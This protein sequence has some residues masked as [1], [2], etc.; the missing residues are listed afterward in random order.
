MHAARH[1]AAHAAVSGRHFAVAADRHATAGAAAAERYDVDARLR[2]LVAA[3]AEAER[4]ARLFRTPREEREM[5]LMRRPVN[6]ERA[7]ELFGLLLGTL[8]PAAIFF[9]LALPMSRS[10]GDGVALLFIPMLFICAALG[11]VM[12]RRVGR[13]IG[14]YG[15]AGWVRHILFTIAASFGWAAVTGAAGGVLFF[16]VGAIFGVF[17]AIAVALPAFVVFTVLHRLLARGGMIDARH[18]RPLAWAVAATAAALLLSP[19]LLPY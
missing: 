17:C 7:Y 11:R 5:L 2:W 19:A 1:T 16:G 12:G 8:P 4:R 10:G 18:L 15:R 6:A 9:R 14:E 13:S 3:D